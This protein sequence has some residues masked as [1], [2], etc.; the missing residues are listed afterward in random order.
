MLL[1]RVIPAWFNMQDLRESA[2]HI[3]GGYTVVIQNHASWKLNS[4][5]LPA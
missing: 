1:R 5:A 2:A 3:L 4:V